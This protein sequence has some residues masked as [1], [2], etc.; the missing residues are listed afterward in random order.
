MRYGLLLIY[1][2]G[3]VW[4]QSGRI[5]TWAGAGSRQSEA[6]QV[7]LVQPGGL[8]ID[9]AGAVYVSD[10]YALYRITASGAITQI[11]RNASAWCYG[12]DTVG[13]GG[14]VTPF[15]PFGAG[16][17]FAADG[18]LVV[19]DNACGYVLRLGTSA[20]VAILGARRQSVT[21]VLAGPDGSVYISES[22][23]HRVLRQ[24]PDGQV[25]VVAGT[26]RAGFGGDDG[27]AA[28]ALLNQPEGLVLAEDGTLYIADSGNFRIRAVDPD[29]T[30]TTRI[31]TGAP[32]NSPDGLPAMESRIGLVRRLALDRSGRLLFGDSSN[33]RFRRVE[34]DGTLGTFAGTG[35]VG[36]SGDGGPATAAAFLD[37]GGLAVASDGTIFVSDLRAHV[38]RR[39]SPDGVIHHFAGRR[40]EEGDKGP[41]VFAQLV[42]PHAIAFDGGGT[43]YIHE[44]MSGRIRTVDPSGRMATLFD[45]FFPSFYPWCLA[46][47]GNGN[48]LVCQGS[49]IRRISPE[50]RL[51][52]IAGSPSE[53]GYSG[54]GGPAL[55]ARFRVPASLLA[56]ADGSIY[57]SDAAQ[58][59]VR[60]I[61]AAGSVETV[62]GTGIAGFSG[63]GGPARLAQ[64]NAPAG[65]AMDAAGNLYIADRENMR[66]RRIGSDGLIRT[67]AGNGRGDPQF[68]DG[69]LATET[70]L[71]WPEGLAIDSQGNLYIDEYRPMVIRVSTGGR[72]HRV[73]GDAAGQFGPAGDGGDGRRAMM[74][75]SGIAADPNGNIYVADNINN[76]VRRVEGLS[77]FTAN[78]S[79]LVFSTVLGA[80]AQVQDIAISSADGEERVFSAQST[81][82]WLLLSPTSGTV[83]GSQRLTLRVTALP[84]GRSG[85]FQGRIVLTDRD[86]RQTTLIPVSLLVSNTPQQMKL[87]K[88]GLTFSAVAQAPAPSAQTI[89]VLNTGIGRMD[90]TASASTLAGGN[91]LSLTGSNGSSVAG[92]TAPQIN[93]SVNPSGLA[94]GAYFGLVTATSSQADNSPQS[95]VVV[96]EVQ[97]GGSENAASVSP[98]GLLY[99]TDTSASQAPATQPVQLRNFSNRAISFA[100]TVAYP[101]NRGSWV[102]LVTANG[103]LAA[104]ASFDL[105]IGARPAGLSPGV[106]SATVTI[107]FTPDNLSRTVSLLLVVGSGERA[108]AASTESKDRDIAVNCVPRRLIPL[109]RTPGAT[110]TVSAGWP[111]AI[112]MIAADDCGNFVTTGRATVSSAGGDAAVALTPIGNGRWTGTWTSN[113]S[114]PGRLSLQARFESGNPLLSGEARLDGTLRENAQQ[115]AIERNG[116]RNLA[117]PAPETLVGTGSLIAVLGSR[118]AADTQRVERGNWP[119]ELAD[120][121]AYIAGRQV[122][123]RE[124]GTG[125]LEAVV[126][127]GTPENTRHQLVIQRGRAY[128]PPEEV[129]VTSAAPVLLSVDGTGRNQ[130]QI[131]VK[132]LDGTLRRADSGRPAL[133]GE[134]VVLLTTGLGET[135]P[136]VAAGQVAPADPLAMVV[137]PLRVTVEGVEAEVESAS[138]EPGEVGVYR[139]TFVVPEGLSPSSAANLVVELDGVVSAPVTLAVGE[140]P[141]AP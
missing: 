63:D 58:H 37:P 34:S 5:S 84:T 117:N 66:I 47:D 119:S 140:A 123:L 4:G 112:D 92:S 80:P 10:F 78:P 22:A 99:V 72:V 42:S 138:L 21:S 24:S 100:A 75:V 131:F 85:Y 124:V 31:G 137:K 35:A 105:G 71:L 102:Q 103:S 133:P 91:W 59:V 122:P 90:W 114:Q 8:A 111:V 88:T 38:V 79:G 57:V 3:V 28:E 98:Q 129:L 19:P 52:T 36:D 70:P 64:L 20:S 2:S 30:I 97:P 50:G 77:P 55:D 27:P 95:A 54:D 135:T 89:S 134:T 108:A 141:A 39:I 116:L 132:E 32:G 23:S 73:A 13:L 96:L 17:S 113:S 101:E 12:P 45:N 94:P 61:D 136:A 33:R 82:N 115:P 76:I 110:F 29:G 11:R 68:L 106:Y 128:S 104:G 118:M 81:A 107:R 130:G 139:V 86:T 15:A 40:R 16:F 18:G 56:A 60:R 51:Q 74:M 67:I 6:R 46:V 25:A 43:G 83:G 109:F 53:P 120:T 41:A 121:R 48:T 9:P 7:T 125:R 127:S 126:P 65:L 69:A 93:V 49:S 62:V 26:G 44:F 14:Q 1:I 87:D